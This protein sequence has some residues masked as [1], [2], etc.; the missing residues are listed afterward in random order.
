VAR[1][2]RGKSDLTTP[3]TS[4][5]SSPTTSGSRTRR[6][7]LRRS[8]AL[9]LFRDVVQ[10]RRSDMLAAFPVP[11]CVSDVAVSLY[12]RAARTTF[13]TTGP[14]RPCARPEP[15]RR[16]AGTVRASLPSRERCD[17]CRRRGR[18]TRENCGRGTIRARDAHAARYR[19]QLFGTFTSPSPSR[20]GGTRRCWWPGSWPRPSECSRCGTTGRSTSTRP[21]PRWAKPSPRR[22]PVP[23]RLLNADCAPG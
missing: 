19:R 13:A 15:A 16:V 4:R 17:R 1:A 23:F 2:S 6:V 9:S 20:P 12:A 5:T 14:S 11:G 18:P 8:P 7:L 10:A 21:G 22:A 3:S